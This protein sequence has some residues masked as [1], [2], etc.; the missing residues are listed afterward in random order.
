MS[1][2]RNFF[3]HLGAGAA[4]LSASEPA[5]AE[6]RRNI[7][8]I[9]AHPGDAFFAMGLPVALQVQLGGEGVFLSLS[10]GEKGSSTIPPARYGSMQQEASERAAKM[11]NARTAFLTYPDG[12]VPDNDEAKFA[13][14]DLIRQ[15]KPDIVVTHWRGSMHKDH[16][17]CYHVVKDAIFYAAL[18]AV[19]RKFPAHNAG[20][21]F[22]ADNWEDATGFK[23]DTY[24]D[25][26]PVFDRWFG[27][28]AA[29]PMWRGETGFRYNDYYRSRAID[30][31]CL[32]GSKYAVALMSPPEQM[33][34]RVREL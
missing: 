7:M 32:S 24:L 34:R 23:P 31:G 30:C 11:L 20:K 4:A 33:V 10:R 2:R 16:T 15:F 25:V 29:F 12:Q 27:A 6:A 5:Q 22:F 13:V 26:T 28:C 21:L 8:A 1:T 9:A 3:E 19:V 14:C 17:A 18:P